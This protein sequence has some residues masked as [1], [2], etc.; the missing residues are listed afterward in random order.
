MPPIAYEIITKIKF[1]GIIILMLLQGRLQNLNWGNLCLILSPSSNIRLGPVQCPVL[2]TA[3]GWTIMA[4]GKKI[5][6]YFK[7]V[8]IVC[9]DHTFDLLHAWGSLRQ[10]LLY[11]LWCCNGCIWAQ[12]VWSLKW[13][14]PLKQ[15]VPLPFKVTLNICFS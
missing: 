2:P 10:L 6:T 14:E 8:H 3:S 11:N 13:I 7:K 9:F 4:S 15:L 12:S 1:E 5:N